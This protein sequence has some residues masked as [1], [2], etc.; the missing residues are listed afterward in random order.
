MSLN[1]PTEAH[2]VRALAEIRGEVYRDVRSTLRDHD[3]IFTSV[4]LHPI[5]SESVHPFFLTPVSP[6]L[7]HLFFG[8]MGLA[9]L[10]LFITLF[11]GTPGPVLAMR[12][13]PLYTCNGR[14]CSP[15]NESAETTVE[16]RVRARTAA[17]AKR[18]LSR[19]STSSVS[20]APVAEATEKKETG[21]KRLHA[22]PTD[23]HAQPEL[24]RGD[25]PQGVYLT[26]SSVK[27]PGFLDE[28]VAKVQEAGGNAV[29]FDVKG[30]VVFYDSKANMANEL[31]LVQQ[32]YELRPTIQALHEKGIYVMAR[33]VAIKDWGF[34]QARPDTLPKSPK[35]GRSLGTEWV[36]PEHPDALEYNRQII[37]ELADADIDEINLDYIRFSTANFGE[38]RVWSGVEK[39]DKVEKFIQMARKAIDEC[40][41][42][43]TRLGLSTY[44]ILGWDYDVNV[45][46]LGQD[47]KR[48]APYVDIISPMAYPAT[49]TSEGYYVQGKHPGPRAYW[50]VYRTLTG[51]ATLLGPEH[52]HKIR[53]WIQGYSFTA[54]DIK[55]EIR[56]VYEAGNSLKDEAG[57]P[58]TQ[59]FC[60]FQVWNA[61]NNYAPTYGGMKSAPEKPD[62]CKA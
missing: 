10:L 45:E 39:A 7:L 41:H 62:R 52:Y 48:F 50:L 21:L 38:L 12:T 44:A 13:P 29:I 58:I 5:L 14:S 61:N 22:A 26:A 36:D 18:A 37:C 32:N 11:S 42:G 57:N 9:S 34:T 28:T 60:G 43:K 49:F 15:V 16:K 56:A 51:Y 23:F 31:K 46:T 4:P 20:A 2:V 1:H 47:V 59:G 33:F 55:Q 19:S 54:E 53:P 17:T 30:G 6:S 8:S 25:T 3:E 35:T 24:P 27:R 40:G